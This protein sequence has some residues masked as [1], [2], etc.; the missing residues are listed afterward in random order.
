MSPD[1]SMLDHSGLIDAIRSLCLRK[2]TGTVL[3]ATQDNQLA[4][5]LL[6]NGDVIALA[7][8]TKHGLDAVPLIQQIQAGRVKFS[9]SNV[10]SRGEGPLPPSH[11]LMQ[12]LA[13][14]RRGAGAQTPET[15]SISSSQIPA[16]L[17]IIEAE[18]VEFIGPMAGIV[19][20]EYLGK[21]GKPLAVSGVVD[22]VN[23][24]TKEIGD[25]AKIKRFKEQV[26]K[27]IARA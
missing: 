14:G 21:A 6:E 2:K 25:P 20:Q 9:E 22:L 4:R 26:W 17:K 16:A 13:E 27:K 1:P 11:E 23:A 3:I 12:L 10:G 5:V 7:C 8:G 15:R 24:V 19:W 18:L